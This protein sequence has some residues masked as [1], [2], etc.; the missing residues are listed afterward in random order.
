MGSTMTGVGRPEPARATRSPPPARDPNQAAPGPTGKT[1]QPRPATMG[2]GRAASG[3]PAPTASPARDRVDRLRTATAAIRTQGRRPRQGRTSN[4]HRRAR[5]NSHRP[6]GVQAAIR[7]DRRPP[8]RHHGP[9]APGGS[10]PGDAHASTG[11]TPGSTRRPA[12]LRDRHR[13]RRPGPWGP[14][15]GP[16]RPWPGSLIMRAEA[17]SSTVLNLC[18]AGRDPARLVGAG[19]GPD[20][21]RG[22]RT[23]RWR[24]V[25]PGPR[26]AA[27]PMLPE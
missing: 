11:D 25:Q 2:L 5:L 20:R 19:A 1:S 3:L 16:V 21:P 10:R 24:T 23:T 4:R 14:Q 8:A 12:R 26:P 18:L 7:S 17:S 6:L 15:T 9:S 22:P 13:G 27:S